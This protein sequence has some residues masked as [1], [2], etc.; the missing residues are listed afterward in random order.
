VFRDVLARLA[1][2]CNERT[3]NSVSPYG[4]QGEV[5]VGPNPV[6]VFQVDF[7]NSPA[8]QRLHLLPKPSSAADGKMS[9]TESELPRPRT[10][11]DPMTTT[12]APANGLRTQADPF[13]VK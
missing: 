11:L 8:E 3:P 10:G 2:L 5:S 6:A 12:K 7:V 13:A 1:V 9:S 4:G